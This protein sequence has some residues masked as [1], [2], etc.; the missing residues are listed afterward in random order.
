MTA[1]AGATSDRHVAPL[2]RRQL[3]LMHAPFLLEG[4]PR[5]IVLRTGEER[6]DVTAAMDLE[7][8]ALIRRRK[9]LRVAP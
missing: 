8:K 6:I 4:S 1:R 2:G 9:R 3:S 5:E 7:G